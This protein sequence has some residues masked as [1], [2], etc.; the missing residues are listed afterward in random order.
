MT[1]SSSTMVAPS[2][3]S[4]SRSSKGRS[5]TFKLFKGLV[6]MCHHTNHNSNVIEEKLDANAYNHRLIHSQLWI[7]EPLWEVPPTKDDLLE[8]IDPFDFLTLDELNNFKMGDSH[9]GGGGGGASGSDN[10]DYNGKDD[11]DE[12]NNE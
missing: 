9:L 12:D 2:A 10:S 7:Q 1:P 6:S 5:G 3:P 4:S 11:D 8:L